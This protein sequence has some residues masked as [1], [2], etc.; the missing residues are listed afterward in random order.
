[1]GTS[2][3][4]ALATSAT[5]PG[6]PEPSSD[7]LE[8]AKSTAAWI[9]SAAIKTDAGTFWHPE[10]DHTERV[11]TISP[12]NGIYSGNAGIVLFFLQ[13]AKAT[14]DRSYLEDAKAGANRIVATWNDA[15]MQDASPSRNLGFYS[16]T[17]G[18]AFTLAEVWKAT[19]D[20]RYRDAALAITRQIVEQSKRS[21]GGAEWLGNPVIGGDAGIALYLLY[22]ADT[23][24]EPAY[25]ELASQAGKRIAERARKDRVGV[26]W[27]GTVPAA[28]SLPQDAYFPNF[29]MGTAGAA[30]TLARLHRATKEQQFIEL[31]QEGARHLQSIATVQDEQALIFYRAPDLTNLYYLGFCHGPT[32]TARLF[33]ELSQQLQGREYAQWTERLSRGVLTSGIPEKQTPGFWNVVC[34]CCGSAGVSDFFLALSDATGRSEYLAF[35]RRVTD[36]ML[37]RATTLNGQGHR[38]YQA[39][40]R[41]KPWEVSAETGYMIGA[42]G[43]GS[44]LIHLHLAG[45]GHYEA[46][47]FPDNPFAKESAAYAG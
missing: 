46:I 13:L 18:I 6:A 21:A 38:W 35:A 41:V 14:H 10:P 9:R 19:Q 26:R 39:W 25:L 43:I 40:T 2:S 22:A 44:N 32:G 28:S 30:Y 4:V 27:Q 42:A 8:A 1:M 5:L 17:P 16:G 47:A 12:P 34:Q 15:A 37:S 3:A 33:Y 45:I 31:A 23:L 24:G 36:Q 20:S 11:K 29:E 7:Y